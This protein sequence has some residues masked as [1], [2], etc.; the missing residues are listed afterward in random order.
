[1]GDFAAV[2]GVFAAAGVFG[3]AAG[4]ATDFGFEGSW[5]ESW[6]EFGVVERAKVF[7]SDR[8]SLPIV[9]ES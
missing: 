6:G 8:N 1:M 4:F 3:A 7:P 2:A 5:G 9:S